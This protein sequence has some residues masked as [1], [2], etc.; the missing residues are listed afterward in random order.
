MHKAREHQQSKKI[1]EASK[2]RKKG[3]VKDT[4]R[5]EE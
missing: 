4:K 5:V 2:K 3:K 1:D